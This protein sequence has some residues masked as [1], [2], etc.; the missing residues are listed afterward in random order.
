MS[1][2]AT[3]GLSWLKPLSA[4]LV[5]ETVRTAQALALAP[6]LPTKGERDMVEDRHIEASSQL[7]HYIHDLEDALARLQKDTGLGLRGTHRKKLG[8]RK[9]P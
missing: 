6:L 1:R 8:Q 9:E 2:G 4:E 5:R 3:R 7:C